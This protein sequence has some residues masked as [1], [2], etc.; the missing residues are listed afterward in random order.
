MITILHLQRRGDKKR[1]SSKRKRDKDKDRRGGK[2][3]R[4]KDKDKE[5]SRD[6]DR[7]TAKVTT[8]TENFGKYGIIR[9]VRPFG[10]GRPCS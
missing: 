3:K 6:K 10:S 5:H 1:S 7:A 4:R 2:K 9:E 8:H